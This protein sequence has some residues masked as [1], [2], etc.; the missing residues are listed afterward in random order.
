MIERDL[1]KRHPFA[2]GLSDAELEKLLPLAEG[3]RYPIGTLIFRE[4]GDASAL[5]LILSGRVALE[6]HVPA[7]GDFPVENLTGGDL[8]GLSWLFPGG[9]WVLSARA[10]ED[11]E[12]LRF[13]AEDVK[14]L[15]DAEPAL[16]LA[17]AK[18]VV[19]QLYQRLERVRLQRLDVYRGES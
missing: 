13:D 8:L 5:Y 16:G 12:A 4:G 19:S 2:S 10:M 7:R 6:Q 11:V 18:H 9:H 17:L 15:M 1:L 14:T 3:V